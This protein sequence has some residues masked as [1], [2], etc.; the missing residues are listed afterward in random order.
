MNVNVHSAPV[1]SA[2]W[3]IKD[4]VK[5]LTFSFCKKTITA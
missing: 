3:Q 5:Y 2:H 1:F 4:P